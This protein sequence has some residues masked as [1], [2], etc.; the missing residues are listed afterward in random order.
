[1]KYQMNVVMITLATAGLLFS[2]SASG[3]YRFPELA[4]QESV[5]MCVAKIAD[6]ANYS[7][8]TRVRHEIESRQRRSIG[9]VLRI[10]TR[11]YGQAEDEVI[12][13]YATKCVVTNSESPYKFTIEEIDTGA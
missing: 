9:H 10:D 1:M 5:D 8:A 4:P 11:V 2:A 6:R 13:E 12:R 7:D 3:D